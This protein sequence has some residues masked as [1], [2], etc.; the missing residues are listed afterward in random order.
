MNI[1]RLSQLYWPYITPANAQYIAENPIFSTTI[2]NLNLKC[3]IVSN[4]GP[5][6]QT[7]LTYTYLLTSFNFFCDCVRKYMCILC[8]YIEVNDPNNR[9]L[10]T[11]Q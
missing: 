4:A 10:S 7:K 3:V 1:K 8:L 9:C 6:R 2:F 11:Q 5:I